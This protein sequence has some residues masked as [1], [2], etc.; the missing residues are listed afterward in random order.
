MATRTVWNIGAL[1]QWTTDFFN[2]R[3]VDEPRLSAELLLAHALHCTRMQLYT[4]FDVEPPEQQLQGFRELVKKRGENVPVA[5]LI[6]KAWF[7]S[8]EF[9]VT[10]DVL[11]PRPDTETLVEH[12][13]MRVRQAPGWET[14]NILDLCTGSGC[15]AIT[16]AKHLPNAK[17]VATDVSEK[18]LAVAAENAKTL[19]VADRVQFLQGDLLTPVLALAPPA[20]FHVIASNPPYIASGDIAGLPPQVRD[21][22]PHLALDGGPDGLNALRKIVQEAQ[23]CLLPGGMLAVEIAYNQ[24][25]VAQGVAEGAPWLASHKLLRDAAGR[26]RCIVAFRAA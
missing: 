13:I 25:A 14:P 10:P 18:A 20:Q 12:I 21:H 15:I 22:E 19:G 5:Y 4:Q 26:D 9:A 2:R 24:A 8:L 23:P 6:G 11:I 1:L 17:L 3:Q 7:Y 16:L